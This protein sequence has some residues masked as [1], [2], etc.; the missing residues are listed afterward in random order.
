MKKK[1]YL[2]KIGQEI[3][4]MKVGGRNIHET[5]KKRAE[6]LTPES[7]PNFEIFYYTTNYVISE[8]EI[9]KLMKMKGGK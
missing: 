8:K 5:I 2:F 6:L 1:K 9:L 7:A 4:V 3:P